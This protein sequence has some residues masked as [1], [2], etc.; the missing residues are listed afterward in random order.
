MQAR[1]ANTTQDRLREQFPSQTPEDKISPLFFIPTAYALNYGASYTLSSLASVDSEVVIGFTGY[2]CFSNVRASSIADMAGRVGRNPLMWWNNPVNDDHDE[3]LYMRELTAHWTIEDE[4]PINTLNSLV[5]NPMNQPQASKV[6]LF[7]LADYA[8]NPTTF[9]AHEN[10]EHAFAHIA[11]PGD[12]ETAEALKTF[13]RFSNST[14]ED[15]DMVALYNNFQSKFSN[16]NLPDETAELRNRLTELKEACLLIEAM[17]NSPIKNYQLIYNDLRPWNAKLKTMSTLV[18]DALDIMELEDNLSRSEGWEKYNR[19]NNLYLGIDTD[20]IYMVSALEDA[21]TKTREEFYMVTPGDAH[22]RSF[23]DFIVE[24]TGTNI[25]GEWPERDHPQIISNLESLTSAT[26]SISNSHYTLEGLQGTTLRNGEYVGIY[27]GNVQTIETNEVNIP[28]G[29]TLESSINGKVWNEVQVSDNNLNSCYI[30]LKNNNDNDI[31]L[32]IN[33]FS[34]GFNV[35]NIIETPTVSTDMETYSTYHINNVIDGNPS[36]YFWSRTQQ[37]TGNY[38]LLSFP[39]S[40]PRH[41]ITITFTQSDQLKGEA[42]IETSNDNNNWETVAKFAAADIDSNLQFSCDAAGRQARYV[43][44]RI[45]NDMGVPNWLQIAEF[46]VTTAEIISTFAQTTNHKGVQITTL[47]D[48]NLTTG[49][50]SSDAGYIQHDF[51]EN[52]NIESI[53]IYHN[54][55]FNTQYDRPAISVFNG[56]DWIEKGYLDNYCTLV[57]TQ[58]EKMVLSVKITWN[59]HNIP[60][61]YEILPVGTP[62]TEDSPSGIN[63]VVASNPVVYVYN[64]TL[65]IKSRQAIQSIILYDMTGRMVNRYKTDNNIIPKDN[66]NGLS[67]SC[68]VQFDMIEDGTLD[69]YFGSSGTTMYI[70]YIGI[71]YAE[72]VTGIEDVNANVKP[73]DGKIY[74]ISGQYV[75]NSFN[76]LKAGLYIQNGKKYIVK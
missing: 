3:R 28:H 1:L 21:G 6:A 5:S 69:F 32:D 42:V 66:E 7:G 65:V 61:L 47:S 14:I 54:T 62:Y 31:I 43:R 73:N 20:S 64:N 76:G 11:Q 26:L 9:N 53:E 36:T 67:G 70:Y 60:D 48:M 75:G 50:L 52:L 44:F 55:V 68:R 39:S 15:E 2:D 51:I 35:S 16:S 33:S 56:E 25:P 10:W 58:D 46:S 22:F 40:K 4:G 18:I 38:I 57:D 34:I 13:A 45:T 72:N 29:I 17:Q 41:N 37:T 27:F 23:I 63:E 8:W 19:L 71:T 49:Y 24:K 74:N 30:R 59:E 12:T